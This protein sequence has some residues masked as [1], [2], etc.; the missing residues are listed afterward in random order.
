MKR[1]SLFKKSRTK[2]K[3]NLRKITAP[4]VSITKSGISK[5]KGTISGNSSLHEEGV[6][7]VELLRAKEFK[8]K[9]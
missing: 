2:S 3:R 7:I 4:R 6:P 8:F 5:L 1:G 9:P